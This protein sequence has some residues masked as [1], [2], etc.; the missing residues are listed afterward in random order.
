MSKAASTGQTTNAGRIYGESQ[1][2]LDIGR[3][4]THHGIAYTVTS[5]L[6]DELQPPVTTQE[7]AARREFSEWD[8]E[9]VYRAIKRYQGRW[10]ICTPG[11]Q[12]TLV[13]LTDRGETVSE[14]PS[15]LIDFRP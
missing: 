15:A 5:L 13:T 9:M 12:D 8:H 4:A 6:A 2:P 7:L 1:R 3:A 11:K 10:F 14:Q